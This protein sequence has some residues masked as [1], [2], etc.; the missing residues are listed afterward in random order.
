MSMDAQRFS[1][2]LSP[3][4]VVLEAQAGTGLL[5]LLSEGSPGRVTSPCGGAGTCGKCRIRIL[6]GAPEATENEKHLLTSKEI[7]SGMRLAC[8]HRV[9]GA[10]VIE[11]TDVRGGS[12]ETGFTVPGTAA[13]RSKGRSLS[14]AAQGY[15]VAVDLGTTTIALYLV[16]LSSGEILARRGEENPQ[17]F[18][19]ADVI[20]RIARIIERTELLAELQALTLAQIGSMAQACAAEVGVE[21]KEIIRAAVV[22]NPTMLH[23]LTGT[24]P[25]GIARYPFKP[26]FTG[27]RCFPVD[28]G[29]GPLIPSLPECRVELLP[30]ASAYLGADLIA[31]AAAVD[32]D[33]DQGEG[34][35]VDI[36]TNGEI[37]LIHGGEALGCATAAGPAFEGASIS[38][39]SGGVSGAVCR[40]EAVDGDLKIE[41]VGGAPSRSLCGS[42]LVDLAALL[43]R[44]GLIDCRGAFRREALTERL[45]LSGRLSFASDS[46]E[47][48]TFRF[49][50]EE[51]LFLTQGDIREFQMAKAAIATGIEL[52]LESAGVSPR[53][54]ERVYL[55][56]GF[57][58]ALRASSALETGLFPGEFAG[59]IE[60]VG[61]AAGMG[62]V[63]ALSDDA[64]LK[65]CAALGERLR[66]F[67]LAGHSAFRKRL[68]EHMYLESCAE[69]SR[70]SPVR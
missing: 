28:S 35:Y 26:V 17:G 54:V 63:R 2:T 27:G 15:G 64:F 68:M 22:G 16:D 1:I 42:G 65:H 37:L 66:V 70:K 29:G 48:Y 60:A 4:M 13:T 41:T 30:G 10:M 9:E 38:C 56:G 24:D 31:G 21:P 40:V 32:L 47:N 49:S 67:N 36:G 50:D 62:A 46:A 55:A 53:A 7:Q 20:S 44:E 51:E 6:E 14:G 11:L 45:P 34:L 61:N 18:A 3:S 52:L 33:L 23:I 12:I 69:T 58:S 5:E 39:G 19:G 43:L 57:G 59:R 25:T 8:R